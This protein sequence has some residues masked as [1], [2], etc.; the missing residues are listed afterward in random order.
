M[1]EIEELLE[2]MRKLRDF[3]TGCPW[4]RVQTLETI[5]PYTLEEIHELADTIERHAMDDLCDE[6]GDLLFHIVF[7]AQIAREGGYFNFRNVTAKLN[8]KLYRR[9]PHVFADEKIGTIEEQKKRWEKIKIEERLEIENKGAN[10]HG[11]L[12]GIGLALPIID[13]CLKMQRRAA[14]VGFDWQNSSQVLEK[15]EE[16]LNELRCEIQSTSDRARLIEEY[17]DLLFTCINLA[18]HLDVDPEIA[19]SKANN[20]F[21]RRFDYLEKLLKD[22]NRSLFETDLEEMETLWQESKKHV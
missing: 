18:R 16:E 4:D 8:K 2:I 20:K 11:L 19:L 3:E 17:G 9:H 13:R 7:Y 12:D 5:L 1:K 21:K 15:V 6:L 22:N 14:G 10:D